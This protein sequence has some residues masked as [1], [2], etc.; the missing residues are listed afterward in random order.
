MTLKT[1]WHE[2]KSRSTKLEPTDADSVMI[3]MT[4]KQIR[5]CPILLGK[6][7]CHFGRIGVTI[8]VAVFLRSK[9]W[10]QTLREYPPWSSSWKLLRCPWKPARGVLGPPVLLSAHILYLIPTFLLSKSARKSCGL[11]SWSVLKV[12]PLISMTPAIL[13]RAYCIACAEAPE[14]PFTSLLV[15]S[16][17]HHNAPSKGTMTI[18]LLPE[19]AEQDPA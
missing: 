18:S 14:I 6:S 3:T 7:R 10:L 13:S 9:P 15:G 2:T 5:A 19:T 17:S 11:H 8:W 16:C 4:T 12:V 1:S